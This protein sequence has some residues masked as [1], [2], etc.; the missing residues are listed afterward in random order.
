M[1]SCNE[2]LTVEELKQVCRDKNISG[3][4]RKRKADLVDLCCGDDE[5]EGDE[6]ERELAE[7]KLSRRTAL[8]CNEEGDGVVLSKEYPDDDD[9]VLLWDGILVGRRSNEWIG[10]CEEMING[11]NWVSGKTYIVKE[12]IKEKGFQW[13]PGKKRYERIVP[14]GK[15]FGTDPWK[16][17]NLSKGD[18]ECTSI[19]DE[20]QVPVA[21]G[22]PSITGICDDVVEMLG[23]KKLG[24][25]KV[26]DD[27]KCQL[28][29]DETGWFIKPWHRNLVYTFSVDRSLTHSE[30]K[31]NEIWQ[32]FFDTQGEFDDFEAVAECN[33]LKSIDAIT[34]KMRSLND[35]PWSVSNM[36]NT[37]EAAT[38]A[39]LD[40]E[41]TVKKLPGDPPLSQ[42]CD[43]IRDHLQSLR[44]GRWNIY[45][46]G[47]CQLLNE[48][49]GWFIS[50]WFK[51]G[52]YN[53]SLK[54]SLNYGDITFEKTWKPYFD[55][56]EEYEQFENVAD[57]VGMKAIKEM[58]NL[59]SIPEQ[60]G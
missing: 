8:A 58:G 38:C 50:P 53:I 27:Q 7:I 2:S 33:G 32:R 14:V 44:L 18:D 22:M 9:I 19:D 13:N 51:R 21:P 39:D 15:G 30:S 1:E 3:Y 16:I 23:K 56:D 36:E 20:I 28:I 57:C 48:H 59:I 42:S 11:A 37:E 46:R 26:Y 25:W 49:A 5:G 55:S 43:D 34:S 45:S 40:G 41:I 31:F 52:N 60:S 24:N 10:Q 47:K 54:R 4:S 6:K 17:A 29:N 35:D 12:T